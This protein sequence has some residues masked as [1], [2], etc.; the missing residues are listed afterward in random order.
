M[1][2]FRSIPSLFIFFIL[3]LLTVITANQDDLDDLEKRNPHNTKSQHNINPIANKHTIT[4]PEGKS[5]KTI[6]KPGVKAVRS[7]NRRKY[8]KIEK[9]IKLK[10]VKA[11]K[12][13]KSE[14]RPKRRTPK[15]IAKQE[16]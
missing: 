7:F 13:A 14:G 10:N 3:L 11:V 15:I 2:S 4:N 9:F 12:N 6:A 16:G 8:N 5:I 1:N